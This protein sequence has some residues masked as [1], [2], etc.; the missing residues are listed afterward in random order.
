MIV[1]RG[2]RTRIP[3]LVALV[4]LSLMA[5]P[6]VSAQGANPR[7]RCASRTW[8]TSGRSA[9]TAPARNAGSACWFFW[10]PFTLVGDGGPA[11]ARGN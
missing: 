2:R 1:H 6:A 11:P 4:W 8:A 9:R 3:G 7:T 5:P 10:A